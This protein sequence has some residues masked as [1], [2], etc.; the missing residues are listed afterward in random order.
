VSEPFFFEHDAIRLFGV[1]DCADRRAPDAGVVLCHPY[2]E[3]K[4]LTDRVLVRFAR[5][6]A[7]AGFAALRFDCRGYGESQGELQDSTLETQIGETL[8]AAALLRS[9]FRLK[10]VVFLGVRLGAT[11]AALAA[12]RDPDVSGLV[13]W[14]PIVS[15]RTYVRELVRKKLAELLAMHDGTPTRDQIL[16]SLKTDGR[17]EF[18]G[19]YL[20]QQMFDDLSAI[21]LPHAVRQSRSPVLVSTL[22]QRNE[23]YGV[24]DAL[25]SAYRA[26]GT[27]ADLVVAEE[28][29]YWDV[30]SMFDAYFPEELYAATL[31]WVGSR[32]RLA[33]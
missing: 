24:Y 10:S 32:W 14:S 26:A 33:S 17:I 7:D 3:E 29:E 5:R 13:L 6:L 28:R 11:I 2:A 23:N 30:R 8:A 25:V 12:E 20:T 22:R 19:G 4:Q 18:D 21:D 31:G 1:I 15:G 16:E 27:S 9:R